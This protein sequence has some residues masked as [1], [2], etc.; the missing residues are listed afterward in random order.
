[1]QLTKRV[2]KKEPIGFY[3]Y[4]NKNIYWLAHV[5]IQPSIKKAK[6]YFGQEILFDKEPSSYGAVYLV[7]PILNDEISKLVLNQTTATVQ[8]IKKFEDGIIQIAGFG[9][10]WGTKSNTC[11]AIYGHI[12]S[13]KNK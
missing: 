2:E 12:V 5:S 3:L 11:W 1:M 4:S 6:D 8:Y 10:E 13:R 9:D 7:S